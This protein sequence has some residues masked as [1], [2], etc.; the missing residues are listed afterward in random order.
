MKYFKKALSLFF[1]DFYLLKN[2]L[3]DMFDICNELFGQL[4]RKIYVKRE[5]VVDN[6]NTIN[7]PKLVI[8]VGIL[9]MKFLAM[10]P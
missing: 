6:S 8:V 9:N 4:V 3:K 7:L 10:N 5:E 2:E 1:I